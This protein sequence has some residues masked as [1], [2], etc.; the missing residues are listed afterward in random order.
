MHMNYIHVY[1]SGLTVTTNA[2]VLSCSY[3]KKNY[4]PEREESKEV[5]EC[6]GVNVLCVCFL[7]FL[8]V[9]TIPQ[10][11]STILVCMVISDSI[12]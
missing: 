1:K 5:R 12:Q 6:C 2:V 11:W 8:V 9:S 10:L 7:S 3:C 4:D